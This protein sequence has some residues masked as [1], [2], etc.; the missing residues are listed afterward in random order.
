[1]KCPYCAEE[2]QD[3]ALVCRYCDHDLWLARP[4]VQRLTAVEKELRQVHGHVQTL[5]YGM[6]AGRLVPLLV[7]AMCVLFTSG[8]FMV[9]YPSPS[10]LNLLVGF[11]AVLL[12]PTALGMGLGLLWQRGP[13]RRFLYFGLGFGLVNLTLCS[14]LDIDD[15]NWPAALLLFAIGQPLIFVTA[16][17]FGR[18]ILRAFWKLPPA[19]EALPISK[20]ESWL[21]RLARGRKDLET[22]YT[23]VINLATQALAIGSLREFIS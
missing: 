9:L 6:T 21:E 2:I 13:L 5:P 14:Q 8:F 11:S 20:V 1:M 18:T 10:M 17:L 12:P 15:F 4:L 3:E 19:Q 23:L 7:A 16:G 22:A